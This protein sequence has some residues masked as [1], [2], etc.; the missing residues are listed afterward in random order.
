MKLY[1]YKSNKLFHCYT[2]CGE[3]FNIIG[4]FKKRYELLGINYNFYKDIVLKLTDSQNLITKPTFFQPYE[5]DFEKY[6]YSKT[7]V[8]LPKLKPHL[9]NIY[10]FFSVPE[11][12]A[13]GIDE[14]TMKT[15]NIRYDIK[16]N[17]IIIPHYDI[18]GNLIGIRGR[19]LNE[20]DIELG[21]YRPVEIEGKIYKHPLG[22]NL[23]GLNLVKENISRYKVALIA[24]GEKSVLQYNT[25]YG[26]ERN[27]CV[28]ACGSSI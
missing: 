2:G 15:F 14:E 4:L 28:A 3:S 26:F 27:I 6:N 1:Y 23:Y 10:N 24:E 7:K 11:W 12:I 21:K 9:L 17:R 5:S 13:D 19:A 18:Q 20:E 25:M 8:T 22:Y 16:N